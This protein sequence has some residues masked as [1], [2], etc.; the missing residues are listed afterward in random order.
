VLYYNILSKP[1]SE[2]IHRV[3]TA[4]RLKPTKGDWI[5]TIRKDF[6]TINEDRASY[7][8]ETI[9]SM[10]I[11]AYKKSMKRKV[12][13]AAFEY[14]ER[15]KSTKSKV[16]DISYKDLSV[17][18]YIKSQKFSNDEVYLLAK[19]RSR[20]ISVKANFS[21]MHD[22]TLCSLGCQETESQQHIL[23]CKPLLEKSNLSAMTKSIHYN[24][25]FGPE[26]RQ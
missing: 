10:N 7:D 24:D 5:H 12:K 8:A 4:Q 13:K 1:E 22:D 19:L 2:L 15:E 14:L 23:V 25:I 3:F 9:G 21:G 6:E 26:K 16:M 11:K 20:N 18:K 17:Q